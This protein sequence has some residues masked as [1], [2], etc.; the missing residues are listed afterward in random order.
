MGF[1]TDPGATAAKPGSSRPVS[2]TAAGAVNTS[3]AGTFRIVYTATDW[4]GLS[5]D[6]VE[7]TVVVFDPC[8]RRTPP[9]ALCA[10]L[11]SPG[12]IVCPT[13]TPEGACL[14]LTPLE[15]GVATS[16]APFSPPRYD[17]PP[18]VTLLGSGSLE[19][20]PDNSTQMTHAIGL[21]DPW[22]DPGATAFDSIDGYLTPNITRTFGA[23]GPVNAS[24][25]TPTGQFYTVFYSISNKGGLEAPRA[26]RR[27]TVVDPCAQSNPGEHLCGP[28]GECSV[29]GLCASIGGLATAG[30]GGA[31][32]NKPP[33]L[34]LQGPQ[35]VTISVG[36][37]YDVCPSGADLS[38]PCERGGTAT[39]P[40]D[41]NLTPKILACAP[42]GGR[43][44]SPA[45]YLARGGLFAC[46]FGLI[47]SS[48]QAGQP[49]PVTEGGIWLAP[50]VFR[51]NFSVVDSAGLAAAAVRTLTVTP[52]CAA[53]ER[54]CADRL[55]CSK[56]GG[57]CT[58]DLQGGDGGGGSAAAAAAASAAAAQAVPPVTIELV[59]NAALGQSVIVPRFSNFSACAAGK[60]P[61]EGAL[62]EPGATARDAA[63]G[64]DDGES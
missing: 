14:C 22:V 13:C 40:E 50:G 60:E 1:Y 33:V 19:R 64:A 34:T 3:A 5:A 48:A 43:A 63:T 2:V 29:D 7:R 57:V 25:A 41:G 10:E 61:A 59:T 53:G 6:T 32:N 42:G 35:A 38:V 37:A 15:T 54:L 21:F 51:L 58:A 56:G 31:G 47:A 27:V 36:T 8:M 28:G 11:S 45:N 26:E 62:C 39:D 23:L 20:F 55:S 16:V 49:S 18:A 17:A 4:T 44:P 52:V 46:L 30:G 24:A 9:A 12:N